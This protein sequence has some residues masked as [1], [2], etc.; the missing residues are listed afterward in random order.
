M[1][2]NHSGDRIAETVHNVGMSG[3]M[4]KLNALARGEV[5]DYKNYKTSASNES[6]LRT[7]GQMKLS[8]MN[9]GMSEPEADRRVALMLEGYGI[10]RADF[11]AFFV[12]NKGEL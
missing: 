8:F 1:F 10:A 9:D 5:T 3:M 7:M 12:E 11:D 6:V 4:D 2:F